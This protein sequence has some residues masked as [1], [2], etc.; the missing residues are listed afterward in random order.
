M[1]EWLSEKVGE[2]SPTRTNRMDPLEVQVGTS[3]AEADFVK[4]VPSPHTNSF[5]HLRRS[6]VS[7]VSSHTRAVD[8]IPGV[9]L[10]TNMG[11]AKKVQISISMIK[12]II[13][14]LLNF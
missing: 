1:S 8:S 2:A 10:D 4:C 7:N 9:Q 11:S 6:S 5:S 3:D 13:I 12:F 14:L